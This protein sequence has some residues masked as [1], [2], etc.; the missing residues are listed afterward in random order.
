MFAQPSQSLKPNEIDIAVDAVESPD[1]VID[2]GAAVSQAMR[3]IEANERT[4]HVSRR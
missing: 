4:H 3:R 1:R 2:R